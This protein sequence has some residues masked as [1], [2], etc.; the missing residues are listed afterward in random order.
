MI[1]YDTAN[2]YVRRENVSEDRITDLT[3]AI[4]CFQPAID[5]RSGLLVGYGKYR[6]L[7]MQITPK[8]VKGAGS[9]PGFIHGTNLKGI[10]LSETEAFFTSFTNIL[11]IH[12]QD[13]IITRID[14]AANLKMEHPPICYFNYLGESTYMERI[15]WPTTLYYK[16]GN[17]KQYMLYDKGAEV[18]AKTGK[19]TTANLLRSELKLNKDLAVQMGNDVTTAGDLCRSAFFK[20]LVEKWL[21][22][23]NK[24][25]KIKPI[26][27]Y[28]NI[29][30]TSTRKATR[31]CLFAQLLGEQC[32]KNPQ[33]L[34]ELM[35][36]L[37]QAGLYSNSDYYNLL[38]KDFDKLLDNYA[39]RKR[40]DLEKELTY[41][42]Y[43]EARAV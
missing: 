32:G 11:G 14:I 16:Q 21:H 27:D 18:I 9:I 26:V 6:N 13:I 38:K 5:I 35:K 17:R 23:Y 3:K 42:I 40:N 25:E 4:S 39:I 19:E 36:S 30:K 29:F 24:I 28:A 7:N 33:F 2:W 31:D 37:K 22:E 41:K 1:C 43:S 12:L 20:K 8:F 34:T 15:I 10:G